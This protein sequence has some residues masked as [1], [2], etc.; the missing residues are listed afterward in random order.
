MRPGIEIS[1]LKV[2]KSY[3]LLSYDYGIMLDIDIKRYVKITHIFS[4]SM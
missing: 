2:Y 4:S 1:C 3:S